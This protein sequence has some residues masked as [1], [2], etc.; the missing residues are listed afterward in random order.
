MK[1]VSATGLASQVEVP[2][3]G[4]QYW[5]SKPVPHGLVQIMTY[6]SKAIGAT[7]QAYVY[8]PPDYIRGEHALSRPLSPA[9]RRG[10]G[11]RLVDDR[12]RAH[13]HGQPARGEES[14]ADDRGDAAGARR[15]KPRPW[16]VRD[17]PG[18][19]RPP[20]R[21]LLAA[22]AGRGAVRPAP[23]SGPAALQPFAQDF[24]GDLMPAVEKTFRVSTRP[25]DRAIGG[26]SAGG[27]ATINTAF[28][29]PDLF[30][31]VIIMSAGGGQNVE[32][33]VS[34]VLRE[35]GGRGQADEADLARAPAT[36]TSR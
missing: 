32:A 35:L 13:H 3:D 7:R 6:E 9:R 25:E 36:R 5:D 23:P 15:W 33:L 29:R 20:A 12:A 17:V 27:A 26:L 31:Y 30:R 2:G 34:E 11:S 28:S 4:P 8:T 1:L 24:F 18:I 10:P 16:P 22:G 19:E 14:E 21:R